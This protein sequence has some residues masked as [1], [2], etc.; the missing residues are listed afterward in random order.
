VIEAEHFIEQARARGFA[1]YSGV[2]CSYLTPF[3]NYSIG[4]ARLKYIGAANEG[5][6]VAIAAGAELA[7]T[8]AVAMFQ[9]SGLGNAVNPLT[10]LTSTFR[11]PILLIITWRGEPGGAPDE[12]QHELMGRITPG[13]LDA[14]EIPWSTFPMSDADIAPT[15]ER[16]VRHLDGQRTPFA[17]LMRK[18]SVA[19]SRL[20]A[21]GGAPPAFA[22]AGQAHRHRVRNY[23]GPFNA[24]RRVPTH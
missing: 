15:L 4:S 19:D 17:L 23:S 2:P 13:L 14:M 10:S 7:G 12:P 22:H 16:A 3:I 21:T 6:A 24:P 5:D 11:I 1:L 8:R 20:A 9:N 18:G